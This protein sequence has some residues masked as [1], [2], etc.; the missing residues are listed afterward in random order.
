M[1]IITTPNEIAGYLRSLVHSMIIVFP[2]THP[3]D[4]LF[5][6]IHNEFDRYVI[7]EH[8]RKQLWQD[9]LYDLMW[10]SYIRQETLDLQGRLTS[11]SEERCCRDVYGGFVNRIVE[12]GAWGT[13]INGTIYMRVQRHQYGPWYGSRT[14]C[15]NSIAIEESEDR[16]IEMY[17]RWENNE[18]AEI[19]SR[20]IYKRDLWR[21]ELHT[22]PF[23]PIH[24]ELL[25][26]PDLPVFFQN[27]ARKAH[28]HFKNLR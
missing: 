27:E 22:I 21:E 12:R 13:Y 14:I 7:D 17:P 3:M 18:I 24:E 2:S 11:W 28:E 8:N 16:Y 25:Y 6:Y 20:V 10:N 9:R 19:E 5:A 4:H 15:L 23:K 1:K 26:S